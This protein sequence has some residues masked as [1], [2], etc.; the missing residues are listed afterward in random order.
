MLCL[1]EAGQRQLTSNHC[2]PTPTGSSPPWRK[3]EGHFLGCHLWGSPL[4][5]M[6]VLWL[7]YLGGWMWFVPFTTAR[8]CQEPQ[9]LCNPC[10]L[11]WN[12]HVSGAFPAPR[13]SQHALPTVRS[14]QSTCLW[15]A[16]GAALA[17]RP[18]SPLHCMPVS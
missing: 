9:D 2:P 3:A 10:S 6:A 1:M 14:L 5:A 16:P 17:V 12:P 7:N 11:P 13:L 18:P 15:L 4:S 8:M